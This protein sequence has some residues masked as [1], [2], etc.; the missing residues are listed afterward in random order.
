[1]TADDQLL[2]LTGSMQDNP[3]NLEAQAPGKRY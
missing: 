3:N 2:A 1:M